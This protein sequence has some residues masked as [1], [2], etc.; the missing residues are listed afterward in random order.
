MEGENPQ[1]KYFRTELDK[2]I[3]MSPVQLLQK[4][5]QGTLL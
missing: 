5:A 1:N 4:N 2:S 3:M